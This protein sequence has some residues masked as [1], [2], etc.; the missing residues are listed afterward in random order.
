M[1]QHSDAVIG[2]QGLVQVEKADVPY[3]E[4]TL[5]TWL[6]GCCVRMDVCLL[7][8]SDY[9]CVKHTHVECMGAYYLLLI[10]N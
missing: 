4:S 1:L 8:R 2:L 6:N 9:M 7:V 3:L 5:H 10:K